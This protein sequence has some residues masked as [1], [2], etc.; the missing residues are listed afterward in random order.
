MRRGIPS[1]V[2]PVHASLCVYHRCT[3]C[4]CLPVCVAFPMY[5]GMPPCVCSLPMYPG[6]PPWWYIPLLYTRVCLP[7]GIYLLIHPGMPPWWVY[8]LIHPGM[9]PWWLIPPL[10]TRVCLPGGYTSLPGCV[11]GG[12]YASLGVYPVYICLPMYLRVY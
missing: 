9:P 7:G 11:P 1:Y 12:I 6:M 8:S 5:Q 2:H 4:T 3:P 10:Y